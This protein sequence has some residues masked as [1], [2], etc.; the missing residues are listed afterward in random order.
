MTNNVGAGTGGHGGISSH[1]F[2]G[3]G[4]FG[5]D[6]PSAQ[7]DQP[8]RSGLE[9]YTSEM[10]SQKRGYPLFWPA[11]QDHHPNI[12]SGIAIG[13]VGCID[14]GG[15][16]Y[17]FNV[18]SSCPNGF[19]SLKMNDPNLPNTSSAEV[20]CNNIGPGS[21]L[22][23]TVHYENGNLLEYNFQ[24]SGRQGAVLA[25]PSGAHRQQLK[26]GF[27]SL[28]QY[29]TE[30]AKSWY[31][32]IGKTLY[33]E[34]HNGDLFVVS[35]HEKARSWGIAHYSEHEE[36]QTF[37]LRF[38]NAPNSTK[39]AWVSLGKNRAELSQHVHGPLNQT[40]FLR[41]WTVSLGPEVWREEFPGASSSA[42]VGSS[43]MSIWPPLS[44]HLRPGMG[45]NSPPVV[46]DA[47]PDRTKV[48]GT[49]YFNQKFE[50]SS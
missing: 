50:P 1:G 26:I 48:N 2:G 42:E 23:R 32:Y 21:C 36:E 43:I 11:P 18:F 4:G 14:E 46:L 22:S 27:R 47:H 9:I 45:L 15:F 28:H 3:G 7:D 39:Y 49:H 40:L 34:I 37:K 38:Q 5:Q 33:R 35:G 13:D 24:C 17:L 29:V 8:P 44:S 25:L 19:N 6:V 12:N 30:N 16:D 31:R 10:L 20:K 41:G